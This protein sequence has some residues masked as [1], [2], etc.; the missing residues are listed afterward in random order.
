MKILFASDMSFNYMASFPGREVARET[1]REAAGVFRT[2]D[3]SVVN[4]ENI[5]GVRAAHEPITKSGPNLISDEAFIEYVD[6][7]SPSVVGLAN[8]HTKDYGEGPMY[9]T[10]DMLRA[11]G[12][13]VIGAGKDIAEAYRP[14]VLEKD[15]RRVAV[16][17]I[18]ENE[19]GIA[20]ENESGTA[21]YRLGLAAKAIFEAKAS[22]A[23]PVIYFHGGNERNPFPSPGKLELYRHF[24]DLGAAAV[25]AMHTHCPQGCETY[26]GAPIVYSM[27]NFFFPPNRVGG[28]ARFSTW[29]M[30][31]MTMLD[32]ADDGS[33]S[34]ELIPYK[35]DHE[36]HTLLQGAE[37][38]KLLA[39]VRELSAPLGDGAQMRRYFDSWCM[40]AGIGVGDQ[41]S[42][43]GAVHDF[44][45]GMLDNLAELVHTKNVFSC[46]AH[47]EL[48]RRS[49]DLVYE[50]KREEALAGVEEIYRLQSF[51]L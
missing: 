37:K 22:G 45:A 9:H 5:F 8:N 33:V 14:A 12:Y 2:A 4:L 50:G 19:F 29:C 3:F 16:I 51:T 40:I 38:E 24:V 11:R 32:F 30:G 46:E 13:Q 23:L 41:L 28:D 1:M 15:G 26:R 44:R 49:L 6:A 7:L 20:S 10:M 27:G 42:Y 48:I 31:Y 43:L 35:F 25:V 18:C 21:G 17:A 36:N 47:N 39:Y 34:M